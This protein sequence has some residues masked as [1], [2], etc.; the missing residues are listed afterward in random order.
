MKNFPCREDKLQT[1]ESNQPALFYHLLPPIWIEFSS[2]PFSPLIMLFV[3][4]YNMHIIQGYQLFTWD[5]LCGSL[6]SQF[7]LKGNR[8]S[9]SL[10]AYFLFW[11]SVSVFKMQGQWGMK[12]EM[13]HGT[14]CL[15]HVY[16]PGLQNVPI[17]VLIMAV[18]QAVQSLASFW[19][20]ALHDFLHMHTSYYDILFLKNKKQ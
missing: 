12:E 17:N 1:K 5:M 8:S 6:L 20:Y 19:W 11:F 15:Q 18:K 16:V 10:D 9:V 7:K 13:Y 3:L 4:I 2:S 14:F